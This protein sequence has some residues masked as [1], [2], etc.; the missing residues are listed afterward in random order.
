MLMLPESS[1]R[2]CKQTLLNRTNRMFVSILARRSGDGRLH[3]GRADSVLML[4]SKPEDR[5]GKKNWR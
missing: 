4:M 5:V 1:S 2:R 3:D